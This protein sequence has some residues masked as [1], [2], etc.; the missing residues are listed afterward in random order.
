M[1]LRKKEEDMDGFAGIY[2]DSEVITRFIH[3]WSVDIL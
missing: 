3:Y 2:Y 1:K